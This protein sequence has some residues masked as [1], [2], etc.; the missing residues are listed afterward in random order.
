M[1]PL[2]TITNTAGNLIHKYKDYGEIE[3]NGTWWT[4]YSDDK[5][6]IDSVVT[7]VEKHGNKLKVEKVDIQL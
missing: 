7:V 2:G 3:I 5:L 6:E 1:K 4:A